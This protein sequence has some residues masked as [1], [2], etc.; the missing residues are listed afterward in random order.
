MGHQGAESVRKR[1]RRAYRERKEKGLCQ[2]CCKKL[3][4]NE[5]LHCK[6][7]I[8]KIR[9]GELASRITKIERFIDKFL[10][11]EEEEKW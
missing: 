1:S 7:C 5:R 6:T 10:K 2:R 4:K 11:K 9:M 3:K 8:I